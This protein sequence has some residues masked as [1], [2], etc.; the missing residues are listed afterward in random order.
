MAKRS[1]HRRAR[2]RQLSVTLGPALAEVLDA[3]ATLRGQSPSQAVASIVEA[4]LV[5]ARH[6]A[7][8]SAS[9]SARRSRVR[10]AA[11]GERRP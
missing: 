5:E 2:R 4:S 10:L 11:V 8:V 1:T 3:V 9:V 6:D 7:A